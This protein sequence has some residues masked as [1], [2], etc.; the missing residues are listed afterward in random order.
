MKLQERIDM[1]IMSA[2]MAQQITILLDAI[3]RIQRDWS[4]GRKVSQCDPYTVT[5]SALK[6]YDKLKELKSHAT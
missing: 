3:Q 1:A 4:P 5:T 6:A 2:V